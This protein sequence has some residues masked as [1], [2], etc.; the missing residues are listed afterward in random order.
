M[1][2]GPFFDSELILMICLDGIISLFM[3]L[4]SS[5]AL[6]FLSNP[7]PTLLE[8][9]QLELYIILKQSLGAP[10]NTCGFKKWYLLSQ[11]YEKGIPLDYLKELD[12]CYKT[13][14]DEMR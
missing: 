4:L 8:L 14:L 7:N 2:L 11:D 1:Q 6:Q 10:Y 9:I 5:S 12:A 13:F 3:L